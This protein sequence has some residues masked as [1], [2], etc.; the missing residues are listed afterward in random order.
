MT[1]DASHFFHFGVM[2]WDKSLQ[3]CR[4]LQ[5]RQFDCQKQ[6]SILD[7]CSNRVDTGRC[8]SNTVRPCTLVTAGKNL[9]PFTLNLKQRATHVQNNMSMSYYF[10]DGYQVPVAPLDLAVTTIL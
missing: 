1:S 3:V 8:T 7:R 4:P 9:T 6:C 2:I 10:V 5:Q